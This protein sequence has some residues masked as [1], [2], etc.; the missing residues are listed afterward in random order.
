[1]SESEFNNLERAVLEWYMEHYQNKQLSDQIDAAKLVKR[2]WAKHGFYVDL[3][4]P[5]SLGVVDPIGLCGSRPIDGPC[6]KS[7]NIDHSGQ[8]IL[9]DDEGYIDCL[10]MFAY[11]ERFAERIEDFE[12]IFVKK[13]RATLF[14]WL[15][16]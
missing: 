7:R 16:A 3:A 2:E 13:P 11:G 14:P 8:A 12:L 10:E 1:M 5:R 15:A 6:I 9:W 4:V